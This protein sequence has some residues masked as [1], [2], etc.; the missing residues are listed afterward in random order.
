SVSSPTWTSSTSASTPTSTR[1][2]T[3]PYSAPGSARASTN[4]SN[5][6]GRPPKRAGQP[7]SHG[8]PPQRPYHG[9]GHRPPRPAAR[10]PRDGDRP[11]ES[12]PPPPCLGSRRGAGGAG[13]LVALGQGRRRG[14]QGGFEHFLP[15]A[16][17]HQVGAHH[18]EIL[19]P[20]G[21]YGDARAGRP[22]LSLLPAQPDRDHPAQHPF[23][24]YRGVPR[25]VQDGTR[26]RCQHVHLVED[27][28]RQQ[29]QAGAG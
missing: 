18:G 25:P 24:P 9:S 19:R 12:V 4:S 27:R 21:Q 10:R 17:V 23:Q 6:R 7:P 28:T 13:R 15:A 11:P 16:G 5:G 20:G 29:L 14:T 1:Y 26:H 8:P 22:D 3:S 2:R